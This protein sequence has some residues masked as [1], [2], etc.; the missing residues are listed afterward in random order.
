MKMKRTLFALSLVLVTGLVSAQK[1]TTSSATVSFDATTE[2]DALP[3]AVN[4]TVAGSVNTET[5]AVA[6]EAMVASFTFTNPKIQEHF[7]GE[8]WM[9]SKE[10]PITL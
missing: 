4:N 7:N 9:N 3:K 10:Y 5:G 2:K 6:F 1:K 8:N